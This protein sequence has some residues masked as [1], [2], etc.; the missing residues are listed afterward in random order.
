MLWPGGVRLARRHL[1]AG[2]AELWRAGSRER[3]VA[4]AAGT[5]PGSP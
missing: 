1:R 3:F 2:I 4:D 5:C